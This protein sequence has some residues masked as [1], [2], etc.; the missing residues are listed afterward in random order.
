M[1]RGISLAN[2]C[3]LLFGG[4]VVLVVLIAL[5][6]PWFRMNTLVDAGQLEVSRQMVNSWERG[7]EQIAALGGASAPPATP[8]GA[9]TPVDFAGV[10]AAR[11]TMEQAESLASADGFVRFAL[12]ELK[13]DP[14]LLDVQQPTWVG[15]TREYRYARAVRDAGTGPRELRGLILL[16]RRSIPA[17]QLLVV[18]SAYLLSAGSFVLALA[19]LV[20]YLITHKLILAPVRAL[21]ETAERVREGDLSI[22]SDIRTGDEFEELAGTFNLMLTDLSSSQDQLRAINAALD[23][24]LTELSESNSDLYES[25]RLKG[26]FLANI[27]HELRTPLNSIIGFAE[28]LLEY[29]RADAALPDPS[30]TAG[31]RVRYLEN[32][33]SAARNLLDLINDLLDMARLEAGKAEVR[34]QK[35]N[36]KDA[37]EALLGMTMPLAEKKG[38]SLKL[39]LG[40]DLP[41][42]ETDPKK[43]HQIV[44]NFLSN[45]VKFTPSPTVSGR[46]EHV[47]LRAERLVSASPEGEGVRVS[48]IDTGPGISA[49]DQ[50]KIFQ[51]F[52]QLSQGHAREHAGTGLG[53]AICKELATLLQGEIQVVSEPGRGSMFSFIMPTRIDPDELGARRLESRFRGALA[54]RNGQSNISG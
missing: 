14:T 40:E 2:K 23:V 6:V 4:A 18:N 32:I 54:G 46:A 19:V 49:E 41:T 45:A 37:C 24:K 28:L 34:V 12:D 30:P 11:L 53:L 27:S 3:L 43:F 38:I 42:V 15:T 20:F 35:M 17:T 26:E 22:R 10:V 21:K 29:A 44:F 51:K 47:T 50:T 5:T 1:W 13:A 16:D 52:Q 48:V 36:L 25:A 9:P 7:Q 39:E 8:D 31:K 33:H